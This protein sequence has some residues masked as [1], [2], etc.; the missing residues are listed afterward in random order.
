MINYIMI[1]MILTVI[2]MAVYRIEKFIKILTL[3]DDETSILN[4]N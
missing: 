4:M 3:K 1:L 2:R